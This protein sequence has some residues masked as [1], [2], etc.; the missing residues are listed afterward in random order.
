MADYYYNRSNIN[1]NGR[2]RFGAKF[3]SWDMANSGTK[4]DADGWSNSNF[5]DGGERFG[6]HVRRP[7]V[8]GPLEEPPK[9]RDF[10]H[11]VQNAA[12]GERRMG[13]PEGMFQYH[14]DNRNGQSS[15]ENSNGMSTNGWKKHGNGYATDAA[16]E[17]LMITGRSA[18]PGHNGWATPNS[19]GTPL[20]RATNG[21][22][23]AVNYKE[24]AFPPPVTMTGTSHWG[25]GTH[26]MLEKSP[27][28]GDMTIDSRE[29][30]KKYN[31]YFM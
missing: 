31:G 21:I 12:S 30:A 23:T 9:V 11:S 4:G 18:Q 28:S 15:Y 3:Q 20:S 26:A 27:S 16:Q 17:H 2:G 29:A 13:F 10:I 22:G 25:S 1:S 5:L 24:S 19:Y 6:D 14:V 8:L 7:G